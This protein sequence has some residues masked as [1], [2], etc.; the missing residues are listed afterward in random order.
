M[1]KVK[2]PN[3]DTLTEEIQNSN[4]KGASAAEVQSHYDINDVS[5]DFYRLWLGKTFAYSCALWEENEGY[6]ELDQAQMR[7]LDLHAVQARVKGAQ[8]VLDIGCGWGEQ[9]RH[10]VEVHG[11]EKTVGLT[12]SN[13]QAKRIKSLE[14][15]RIE[16]RSE[17]WSEHS[18]EQLYNGIISVGAFEHFSKLEISQEEKLEGYRNFFKRC[19]EW[20]EPSGWMSLQT[21]TY[22]NM[23]REDFNSFIIQVLPGV[24]LPT[25]ADIAKASERLFEIVTLQN[26]REH[27][28]RTCK[29][30]LSRLRAN[31]ATAINLVGQEVVSRYEKYLTLVCLSFH[32]GANG[33]V[34]ITMQRIDNPRY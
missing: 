26:D 18:P 8:R 11:V 3:I 5:D 15:P 24:D 9:L 34:R 28:E 20:L 23:F 21:V 1:S 25:I 10:L 13:S 16:V 2:N 4:Y 17:G 32:S 31:R 22:Q 29:A 27:Y 14:N 6:D 33:L 19:H 30:W 12:L 7:K